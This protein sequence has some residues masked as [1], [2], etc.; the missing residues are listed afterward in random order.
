MVDKELVAVIAAIPDDLREALTRHYTLV[1]HRHVADVRPGIRLAL[2]TSMA[3]AREAAMA[4][5]PDLGLI[6]CQGV[7]LDR[8]DL[9]AAHRRGIAVAHTPDVLTEDVAD[10]AVALMYGVARKVVEADN[11]VR[12]ERWLLERMQTSMRLHGKTAGVVG[13][14]RIGAAVARRAQGIGMQVLWHGPRP[15]P[16]IT[17]EYVPDLRTLAQRSDILLLTVPGGADTKHLV[18][19]N[20]LDALGPRG[21]LVNVARGSVVDEAALL[22]A[23]EKGHIGGAGLDVFATEPNL[24]PRFLEVRNVVLAPHYASLTHENRA[25]MIAMILDNI[26]AWRD[27]RPFLNAAADAADRPQ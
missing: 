8:I 17:W 23:L 2:T 20:V 25:D 15:K 18:E 7:G 9:A 13:L 10:F 1:D 4:S 19:A 6:A 14:G 22:T 5:L 27:G 21:I 24:D 3:G 12:A 16:G 26:A 11:F